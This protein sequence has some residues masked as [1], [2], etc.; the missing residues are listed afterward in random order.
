MNKKN[1]IHFR[2]AKIIF[3]AKINAKIEVTFFLSCI[4]T[5]KNIF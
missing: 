5:V 4:Q 2:A 1:Y 3:S